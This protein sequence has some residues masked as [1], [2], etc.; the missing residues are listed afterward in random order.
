METDDLDRLLDNPDFISGIHNYCDRWCE[1]CPRTKQC[2]NFAMEQQFRAYEQS[3]DEENER[4]WQGLS[5][6][7]PDA[8]EFIDDDDE[9]EDEFSW[10]TGFG[11]ELDD[12]LR[13]LTAQSHEC[14]AGARAYSDMVTEWFRLAG[15]SRDLDELQDSDPSSEGIGA[16]SL[17]DAMAVI[18]WYQHLTY[19]KTVRAIN[20]MLE[21]DAEC[22]ELPGDAN[23]SAKVVLVGIDRSIAAWSVLLK[24]FPEHKP[25]TIRIFAYLTGL[26]R[27]IE[28]TF[29]DA[30][31]FIRPGLDPAPL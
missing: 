6:S 26:R 8:L 4:F 7:L 2:L 17:K 27:R 18:L 21:A 13:R 19:V 3:S 12:E 1:R 11:P 30:R 22:E 9:G 25:A 31:A 29:P 16:I 23:G 10:P 5:R 14:S 20:G 28:E 15:I 24:A